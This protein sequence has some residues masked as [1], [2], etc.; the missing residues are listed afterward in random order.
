[1]LSEEYECHFK[2][3]LISWKQVAKKFSLE[4]RPTIKN[5]PT[6]H[7][8]NRVVA[9]G[10]FLS[11]VYPPIC[12][13]VIVLSSHRTTYSIVRGKK[14]RGDVHH[15][16]DGTS[17]LEIMHLDIISF[18]SPYPDLIEELRGSVE[19]QGGLASCPGSREAVVW[20]SKAP[21]FSLLLLLSLSLSLSGF[22]K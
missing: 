7:F 4:N 15:A 10:A 2:E 21:A 5:K 3:F 16:Q 6:L 14:S 12:A 9:K 20:P 17:Y 19:R 11:K 13:I 8:S 1:M 18:G 22:G